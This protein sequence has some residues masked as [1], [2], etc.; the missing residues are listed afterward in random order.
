MAKNLFCI[1]LLFVGNVIHV[2]SMPSEETFYSASP[3]GE[4]LFV[5]VVMD[6]MPAFFRDHQTCILKNAQMLRYSALGNVQPC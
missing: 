3:C 4:R 1:P 6:I 5:D 2:V